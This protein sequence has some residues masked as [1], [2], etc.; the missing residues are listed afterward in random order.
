M[1]RGQDS[2]KI[3]NFEA[4]P[5]EGVVANEQRLEALNL[6]VILPSA[7]DL[8]AHEQYLAALDKA[9]KGACVWRQY[10]QTP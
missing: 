5:T 8:Q 6:L 10:V 7:Q 9:A 3:D 1:T 2:L 4:P